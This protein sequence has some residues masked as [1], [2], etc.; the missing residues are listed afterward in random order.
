MGRSLGLV[1]G[2]YLGRQIALGACRDDG[3]DDLPRMPFVSRVPG[4][5]LPASVDLRPWMTPVEDQGALGSCTA[6][7]VVGALE[8]LAHRERGSRVELS[9]LFVY[10][11]QRLWDGSAREDVGASIVD[12]VRVV[13]RL[14]VPTETSWP[15][16]RELFAVQPPEPIY[17]E[18]ALLR[19]SDWWSV[20]ID[21]DAMRACLASGFPIVLGTR[22]TESFVRAPRSGA[23][24]LPSASDRDDARHGRHA[25]LVVGYDDAARTFVV[26]N[27]WGSDWGDLGYCYV[28]YPYLGN[29]AWTRNAWAFRALA[30]EHD[31]A[32]RPASLGALP[33]APPSTG[34]GVGRSGATGR[35]AGVG[36]E[37]A[38]SMLGGGRILAGLVGGVVAG[39]T[40]GIAH[41]LRGRDPGAFVGRDRSGEILAAM[42]GRGAAPESARRLPWDDG[43]DEEAI[44]SALQGTREVRPGR[45][46]EER[47]RS[48]ASTDAPGALAATGALATTGIAAAAETRAHAQPE[49][50]PQSRADGI[51]LSLAELH[52]S[53]GGARGPLGAIVPPPGV[54]SE[55]TL[56]GL[57]VQC[58]GGG[59]FAWEDLDADGRADAPF[60]LRASDPLFA[61]WL[62]LGAARAAC[63]WPLGPGERAEDGVSRVLLCARGVIVW[64]P[65]RGAFSIHGPIHAEWSARGGLAGALGAPLEEASVPEDPAGAAVQRFERGVLSWSPGS[66]VAG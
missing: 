62:A 5:S 13:A 50:A 30:G 2:S 29:R 16:R 58:A 53:L 59:L 27:S 35:I 44:A 25:L 39:V 8:Y 34:G 55:G 20:P 18:A 10:F 51:P 23:I 36:A 66:G 3:D 60:V 15:Y 24:P 49:T 48:T 19:A 43:L 63:G 1:F 6:N 56:R 42:R 64:H 22:V 41:G 21:V 45:V 37:L 57:A 33:A 7:A 17:R 9:R 31:P 46:G 11:N 52:A 32:A 12:G 54:M 28:P 14:G 61:R 65:R 38:V 40:P 4:G 47:P 26:R